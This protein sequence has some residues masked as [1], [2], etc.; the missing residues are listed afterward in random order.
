M[1]NQNGTQKNKSARLRQACRALSESTKTD[2]STVDSL[3]PF[4]GVLVTSLMHL[5]K[6]HHLSWTHIESKAAEIYLREIEGG[7]DA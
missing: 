7:N 1:G 5:C 6:E 3:E 4:I 2:L